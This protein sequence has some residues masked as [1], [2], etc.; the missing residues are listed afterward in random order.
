MDVHKDS[1]TIAVLPETAK[2]PTR[3]DRLPN[4]PVKLNGGSRMRPATANAARVTKPVAPGTCCIAHRGLPARWGL[5]HQRQKGA[6]PVNLQRVVRS[7]FSAGGHI[8]SLV[9]VTANDPTCAHPLA[10][11]IGIVAAVNFSGP[12]GGL[13]VVQK[14]FMDHSVPMMKEIGML[15]QRAPA[16]TALVEMLRSTSRPSLGFTDL[17]IS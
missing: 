8:S 13:D 16:A 4:D 17:I 7:G 10:P 15:R 2:T 5:L 1:I 11:G 6:Y 9:A 3:L 14:E 12:V